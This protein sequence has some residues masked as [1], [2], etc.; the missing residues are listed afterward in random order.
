MLLFGQSLELFDREGAQVAASGLA[1]GV[2]DGEHLGGQLVDAIW[3]QV[4]VGRQWR[5][6][7][8]YW[9]MARATSSIF[10]RRNWL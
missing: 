7:E 5:V 3:L 4:G 1:T 8:R 9:R 2:H 10:K 6:G